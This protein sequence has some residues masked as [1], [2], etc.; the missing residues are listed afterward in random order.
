[1]LLAMSAAPGNFVE[2]VR[3]RVSRDYARLPYPI[4]DRLFFVTRD[5]VAGTERAA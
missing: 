5:G 1:M 2:R 3:E 4:T